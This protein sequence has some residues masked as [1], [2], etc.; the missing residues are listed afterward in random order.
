[1]RILLMTWACDLDDVSEPEISARWVQEI[2]KDHQVTVFAV[3]KPDR[4]GCVRQQFPN[5]EVI[6]WKDI[7]VPRF[8]EK[9]RAVVKPGYLIYYYKAR[10][11]LIKYLKSNHFDLIHHVTPLSWRYPSPA[12]GLGVPLIRGPVEGGLKT[13]PG[14]SDVGGRKWHPYMFL[15]KADWI[16][17]RFFPSLRTSSL[18][19]DHL[20]AAAP[21]VIDLL[22]KFKPGSFSVETDNGVPDFRLNQ[23]YSHAQDSATVNLI[24]VGRI[25]PTKGLFYAIRAFSLAST[26]DKAIFTVIGDGEDLDRCKN[27]AARLALNEKV[28]FLGWRSKTEVEGYYRNSDIFLFPSFREPTGGVFLEAM[29][30]GLPCITCDYGGPAYLIDDSCGIKVSPSDEDAFVRNLAGAIDRLVSDPSLR[31]QMSSNSYSRAKNVFSWRAKRKRISEL[32]ANVV[33]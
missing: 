13:P 7:F 26:K 30:F 27:E 3:S 5:L 19:T 6:E 21:Y 1:M 9:F 29:A 11:F 4:F 32:Y 31:M 25:V 20:L 16:L 15:R 33:G 28:H 8:F 24:F 2:S 14:L 12:A 23:N 17:L 10:R 22:G 18:N